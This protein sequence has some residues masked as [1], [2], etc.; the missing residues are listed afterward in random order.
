M[1]AEDS[2]LLNRI[3]TRYTGRKQSFHPSWLRPHQPVTYNATVT[4]LVSIYA[5]VH[6]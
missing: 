6:T 5:Y 3:V 4:R 1:Y 2:Y